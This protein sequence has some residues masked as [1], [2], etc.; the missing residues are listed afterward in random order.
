MRFE[1]EKYVKR[2]KLKSILD[3]DGGA[4][5]ANTQKTIIEYLNKELE[6]LVAEGK[7]IIG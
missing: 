4:W 3:I 6:P 7:V 5:K 1:K 2:K